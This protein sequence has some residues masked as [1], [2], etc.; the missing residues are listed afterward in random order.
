MVRFERPGT[1]SYSSSIA[2]MAVSLTVYEM[3]SVK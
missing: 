1:V 3:F 2:T